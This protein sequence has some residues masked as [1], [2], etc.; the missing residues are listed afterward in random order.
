MATTGTRSLPPGWQTETYQSLA[1][2]RL[3]H[4]MEGWL[5][6]LNLLLCAWLLYVALHAW[7]WQPLVLAAV[8]YW[9][10]NWI[11][12]AAGRHDP[13]FTT[14]Y[15]NALKRPLVRPPHGRYRDEPR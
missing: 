15:F 4:G 1:Q 10:V 14:V 9:P 12:R 2:P 7:S 5:W 8:L 11:M 6:S 3:F 13:H